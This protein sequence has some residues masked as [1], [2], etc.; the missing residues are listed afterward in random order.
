MSLRQISEVDSVPE[1]ESVDEEKE[2]DKPKI[3]DL[4]WAAVK[5]KEEETFGGTG[6]DDLMKEHSLLMIEHEKIVR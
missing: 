1:S 4:K 5:G 2:G 6:L 3:I